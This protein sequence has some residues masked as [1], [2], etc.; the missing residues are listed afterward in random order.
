[1]TPTQRCAFLTMADTGG[2]SIDADLAIPHLEQLGWQVEWV[3]WDGDDTD[4]DR[5]DAVY[6]GAA[7][8]YPQA[9]ARF[10]EVLE[11]IDASRA[12]LVNDLDA[13]RWNLDKRYLRDL[14]RRAVPIVPTHWSDTLV[15]DDVVGLFDVLESDRVIVK[16]VVSTNASDTFLLSRPPDRQLARDVAASFASR[17]AMAQPFIDAVQSEG[18]YSLFYFCGE[19]SHAVLKV[20]KDTDFRVQEE[21]GAS[22]HPVVPEPGL[23][24]AG[25]AVLDVVPM[26]LAYARADFVRGPESF[27]LMELELVEPS[28][29]LRMDAAAPAR[30]AKAFV[31]AAR[32]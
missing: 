16:P 20:P 29:Y 10:I 5:F 15:E 25:R 30:F 14:E 17:P 9:P 26:R 6:L 32:G 28:M 3:V 4:W 19:L 8:D 21:H 18:E 12:V 1:M 31:T 13:V 23:V 7:W 22:I 27:L 2:W 24:A 11:T